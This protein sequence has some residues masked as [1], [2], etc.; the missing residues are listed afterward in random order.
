[1]RIF[2]RIRSSLD[3]TYMHKCPKDVIIEPTIKCN[4]KCSMC[5]KSFEQ[6]FA[7]SRYQ[8][9]KSGRI[10]PSMSF[11]ILCK[12]LEFCDKDSKVQF[13]GTGE[14]MMHP[15]ILGFIA[16]VKR[17]GLT[18]C[19]TTNG[20][21]LTKGVSDRLIDMKMDYI[22]FSVD[23]ATD[24][25]YKKIRGVN[26]KTVLDNISYLNEAKKRRGA[27][28][29][30]IS[31]NFVGMVSNISE[32]PKMVDLGSELGVSSIAVM[33]MCRDIGNIS[34]NMGSLEER[35]IEYYKKTADKYFDLAGENLYFDRKKSNKY[36]DIAL[37]KAKEKDITLF[38]PYF[39]EPE[40][41]HDCRDL[42]ETLLIGYNGDIFSCCYEKFF[43]GNLR[44]KKAENIWNSRT[45][46]DLRKR[47]IKE[48]I[49][50]VCPA[51]PKL[52]RNITI[53]SY[54]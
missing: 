31:I 44:Y 24:E 21:L 35:G 30:S 13:I 41:P 2:G 33:H 40:T 46:R 16:E 54:R 50:K 10:R 3:R 22:T 5:M 15:N 6:L 1:M 12:A 34:I 14:P 4:L 27:I 42:F 53:K 47:Y 49:A 17:R 45:V 28:L 39:R 32:L 19:M 8:E 48:G 25:T 26:I 52:D 51:C 9:L 29:P 18:C 11:S 20:L 7:P 36:I 38:A 23:G 37:E 43:L